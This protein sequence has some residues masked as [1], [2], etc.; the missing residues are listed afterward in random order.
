MFL[1]L[2]LLIRLFYQEKKNRGPLLK[3]Y[4][5]LVGLTLGLFAI[6]YLITDFPYYGLNKMQVI[7]D[8]TNQKADY[9]YKYST[10]AADAAYSCLLYTSGL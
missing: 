10:P 4:L 5:I 7:I 6:R 2:I 9:A 1:F 3:K 8:V